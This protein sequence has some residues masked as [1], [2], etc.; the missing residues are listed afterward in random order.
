MDVGPKRD[1]TGDLTR[2]VRAAGLRMGL[3][4]SLREWYN[5][6]YVKDNENQCN[7]T[8][9]PDEVLIPTL[10]EMVNNYKVRTYGG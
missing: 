7:T 3:Y 10:H 5:P 9:F 4:H 6:L 2:S 1:L 8:T